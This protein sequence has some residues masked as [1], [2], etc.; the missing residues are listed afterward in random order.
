MTERRRSDGFTLIELMLV[1]VLIGILAAIAIPNFLG[2]QAKARRSE[3]YSNLAA[4]ATAEKSYQAEEGIFLAV[5]PF[6]DFT[7]YGGLGVDKMPWDAASEAAFA[8]LGWEPEGEVRY[9]YEINEPSIGGSGCT[10]TVCFTAAAHGN[11]DGDA[12]STATMYAHPQVVGGSIL[13]CPTGMFSLWVPG[14]DY[15]TVVVHAIDE[16]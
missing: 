8:E 13:E 12:D 11:V 9:T 10:C 3:S 16:F 15:D 2:Y 14:S 5:A 7:L 4:I 1:V 6:P